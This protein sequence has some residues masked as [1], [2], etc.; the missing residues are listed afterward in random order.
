MFK[1]IKLYFGN[2]RRNI[3]C[4]VIVSLLGLIAFFTPVLESVIKFA[5]FEP[6]VDAILSK[7]YVEKPTSLT[8]QSSGSGSEVHLEIKF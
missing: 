7:S 8:S 3:R 6:D 5:Q 4:F 2:H 1:L